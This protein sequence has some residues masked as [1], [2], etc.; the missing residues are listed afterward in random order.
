MELDVI[1]KHRR[2]AS[3][4]ISVTLLN[5][6]TGSRPMVRAVFYALLC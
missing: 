4:P 2:D 6:L 5:D 1:T 3:R